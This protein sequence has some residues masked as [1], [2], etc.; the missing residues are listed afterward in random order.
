MS[1]YTKYDVNVKENLSRIRNPGNANDGICEQRVIFSNNNNVYYGTFAG[2]ISSEGQDFNNCN[3]HGGTIDGTTFNNVT[4][5]N[6]NQIISLADLTSN[7]SEVSGKIDGVIIEIIPELQQQIAQ[8]ATSAAMTSISSQLDAKISA[9]ENS[10]ATSVDNTLKTINNVSVQ[11]ST[12]F[13]SCLNAA[14]VDILCSMLSNDSAIC[15][16]IDSLSR[17]A[18]NISSYLSTDVQLSIYQLS[19]EA[20]AIK[21]KVD[22]LS[23]QMISAQNDIENL[24]LSS[25]EMSASIDNA[26]D[27]ISNVSNELD[28]LSNQFESHKVDNDEN[29]AKLSTDMLSNIQNDK[30]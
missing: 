16:S 17:Y 27:D 26:K 28:N 4:L 9:L 3:I 29:F 14:S 20:H 13:V 10:A 12:E 11:L 7:V 22:S 6:G 24:Q 23:I 1:T 15:A 2:K 5:K 30:L 19:T 8:T 25:Q 18:S 21:E